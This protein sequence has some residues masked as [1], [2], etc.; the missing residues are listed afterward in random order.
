MI[1]DHNTTPLRIITAFNDADMERRGVL[2]LIGRKG[3]EIIERERARDK[4][5][6]ITIDIVAIKC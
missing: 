4:Y 1:I 6:F 5:E 2:E 3:I